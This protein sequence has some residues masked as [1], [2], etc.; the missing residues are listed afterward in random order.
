MHAYGTLTFENVIVKSS[1]VGAIKAGLKIGPERLGRYINR[2]GFGQALSPDF[3]GE[4]SGIVW[5]PSRLDASGLASVSMGYQIS[6]T[7]LQMVSAVSSVANGGTLIEPRIVRAFIRN[8]RREPVQHKAIRRTISP[9]TAATM[10]QIMEAVVTDGT[11]KAAQVEGF[12]V[13]GKT[14]TA[15]KLVN[16]NYSNSDYNVSFVGFVPSRKPAL[17]IIVMIDSPHG[18][19]TAY[20][21]TVAAPIFKRIAEASLR[22]LGVAPT[23][24]APSPIMVARDSG[25]VS[26]DSQVVLE[27]VAVRDGLVPDVRG[28]SAREAVGAFMRAGLAPRMEGS[29]FV[30][31]QSPEAG[32]VLVPGDAA[33]LTLRRR[34]PASPS[35]GPPQ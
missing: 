15:A 28:L 1:N 10:T 32:T 26:R 35:G 8:G 30:V 7:P 17:A 18:R 3:R 25:N 12:T 19:V 24:N 6:V 22:Q 21:G 16:G 31:E 14:G 9:E 20:G 13:A 27:R 5:N 23:V 29:G 33:M 11:A 34:M 2:F 4:S